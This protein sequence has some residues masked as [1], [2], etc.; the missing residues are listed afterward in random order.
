MQK[1][2]VGAVF[3][4]AWIA[5]PSLAQSGRQAAARPPVVSS[6]HAIEIGG[7]FAEDLSSDREALFIR[8]A[9]ANSYPITW[10][11]ESDAPIV[12]WRK[13]KDSFWIKFKLQTNATGGI[14]QCTPA[15]STSASAQSLAV[16]LCPLIALRA[17]FVPALNPE[18]FAVADSI[19]FG[20]SFKYLE[21]AGMP[22]LPLFYD[23]PPIAPPPVVTIASPL[24]LFWPPGPEWLRTFGRQPRFNSAVEQPGKT[25]L[26][27]PII[28]LVISD[29]ASQFPECEIV[30]G[31]GDATL[32]GR[33]CSHVLSKL[34]P[35]WSE[36]ELAP[37]RRW[38]L[39]LSPSGAGFRV[40]QPDAS[41][42]SSTEIPDNERSR[43]EALWRPI[44]GPAASVWLS[45]ALGPDQRPA[46]CMIIESSGNDA[47]D[48]AACRL[49]R[50][51][52]KIRPGIDVF[53][54]PKPTQTSVGLRM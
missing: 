40:V 18:G 49:F 29:P 47:A 30:K 24:V 53:G 28:G 21:Q 6:Q 12:S 31:S 51:E 33:A 44:A 46:N 2:F 37:L 22:G 15:P 13:S 36:R 38:P 25:P 41:L 10:L 14:S 54:L 20:V 9:M 11:R 32:D 5:A 50:T 8:R 4:L 34:Q 26:A 23:P 43:L 3:I 17:R 16:K 48:T 1:R 42:F 19:E 35:Q 27:A 7:A 39:Q 45:G 52:A